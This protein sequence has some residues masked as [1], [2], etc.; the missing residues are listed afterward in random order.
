[1]ENKTTHTPGPWEQSGE[2]IQ[3]RGPEFGHYPYQRARLTIATVHPLADGQN[4][5]ML[6]GQDM[7]NARLIAAAPDLLAAAKEV[8][9]TLNDGPADRECPFTSRPKMMCDC[10]GHRMLKNA[11]TKAEGR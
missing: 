7:A 6:E 1:M 5:A 4:N 8:L 10:V 9:D 11:I 2:Y 3:A